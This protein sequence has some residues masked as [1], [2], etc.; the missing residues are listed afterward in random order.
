MRE[1]R[2]KISQVRHTL[3]LGNVPFIRYVVCFIWSNRHPHYAPDNVF[4]ADIHCNE[5]VEEI[6]LGVTTP[7]SKFVF[8]RLHETHVPG[9]PMS[10]NESFIQPVEKNIQG[11]TLGCSP[12][13]VE[14]KPKVEFNKT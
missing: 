14:I 7:K 8:Q 9:L 4:I 5:K 12:G 10:T 2:N 1:L 11:E 13:L 3:Y 6:V